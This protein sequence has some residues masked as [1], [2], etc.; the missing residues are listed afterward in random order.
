MEREARAHIAYIRTHA[1]AQAQ[2]LV[3]VFALLMCIHLPWLN[4]CKPFFLCQNNNRYYMHQPVH[5]AAPEH[6]EH[7]LFVLFYSICID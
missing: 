4:M 6:P 3:I 5:E 2:P 7:I 1:R